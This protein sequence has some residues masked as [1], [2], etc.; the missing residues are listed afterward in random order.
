M[1]KEDKRE[2]RIDLERVIDSDFFEGKIEDIQKRLKDIPMKVITEH[3]D[4]NLALCHRFAISSYHDWGYDNH[5]SVVYTLECY[6]WETDEEVKNRIA[7]E[8]SLADN[9]KKRAQRARLAKEKR[10]KTMYENLK[11]KFGES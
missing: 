7:K 4:P 9:K 11:K 10:E 5:S 2:L 1:K 6:R 8:K 3:K